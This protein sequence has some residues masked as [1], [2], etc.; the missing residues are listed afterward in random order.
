MPS[1]ASKIAALKP[2]QQT[3]RPDTTKP[4]DVTL[5][6]TGLTKRLAE[7]SIKQYER[8]AAK[9]AEAG[10]Q[11]S[12]IKTEVE[13]AFDHAI[14]DTLRAM[15]ADWKKS[16]IVLDASQKRAVE[17]I[18]RNKCSV[19]IG[20]AGTGKTTITQIVIDALANFVTIIDKRSTY[21]VSIQDTLGNVTRL[22]ADQAMRVTND[23]DTD[24]EEKF[25]IPAIAGAA[26]TGRASQQFKRSV[27]AEFRSSISTIHMMLG[28]APSFEE[29]VAIDPITGAEFDKTKIVF[30]PSFDEMNKLPFKVFIFDEA[31]MIPIP[32]W[33]DFIAATDPTVR[34]L[35]IGDINQ[36][37]PVYGKSILGYG[38][39]KWPV[40]ELTQIHRQAADNGIIKNAHNVLNGRMIENTE[41]VH[42]IGN[43]GKA[44]APNSASEMKM[45]VLNVVKKLHE[46]GRYDPYRDVIIV[47][48]N[49][50]F[51][52]QVD[53]NENLVTM[54]NP[55]REENGI[56]VN[57]RFNIHTGTEHRFFAIGDKVMINSNIND[58]EPP[59]TN[60]MIGIVETITINGK[61]DQKRSQVNFEDENLAA[62]EPEDMIDFE[63]DADAINIAMGKESDEKEDKEQSEDQRQSS[64]VMVI[65]F[66]TGQIF[67]CSTAGEYRKV[68]H[69]YAVT[70]HK[71]QGGEYPN[72]IIVVHS[73]NNTSLTREWLYTALTRARNYAYILC[74]QR[75][76]KQAIT[77]Q[78]IK[79]ATLQEKIRAYNLWTE[80]DDN[81]DEFD[82][83]KHPILFENEVLM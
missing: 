75:G 35:L 14:Q 30:R 42:L 3:N 9:A 82:R 61:Y 83:N 46:L 67:A 53:L 16:N 52:G 4:D 56:I 54:F 58:V 10:E 23:N 44:I 50:G 63:L 43:A 22:R 65:K 33:N 48:W 76:L 28:F 79:G 51:I 24:D 18:L 31:S 70:C 2:A 34:I 8:E 6:G 66:E 47:P 49:K 13:T 41:N 59:I 25:Q 21:F 57:K 27:K 37:P 64:H 36:L 40:F 71:A 38:M 69:G 55:Q 1:F 80:T 72:A 45:F 32:L 74:N 60:G 29:Y 68:V 77:R 17:G 20:A 78:H 5:R 7:Q 81:M 19:M 62:T 73:A 26:Y 15:E 39:R 11:E 12:L